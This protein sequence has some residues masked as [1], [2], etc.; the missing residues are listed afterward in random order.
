MGGLR[1]QPGDKVIVRASVVQRGALRVYDQ[2]TG[3]L[4]ASCEAPALAGCKVEGDG[5]HFT[6]VVT[7]VV[8]TTGGLRAYVFDTSPG[9]STGT[10]AADLAVAE[11]AKIH[12]SNREVTVP[13]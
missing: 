10:L 11:R 9:P 7:F 13:D 3:A 4:Q 8:K 12:T 6:L 1:P 2:D 5:E